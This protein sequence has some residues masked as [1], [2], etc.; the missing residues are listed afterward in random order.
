[1]ADGL[2][3]YNH[4]RE[5]GPLTPCIICKRARDKFGLAEEMARKIEQLP[6]STIAIQFMARVDVVVSPQSL[7]MLNQLAT[8]GIYGTTASAVAS[9]FVDQALQQYAERPTFRAALGINEK[10]AKR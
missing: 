3:T 6:D 2:P 1:M 10:K 5:D 9:R 4:S 7:D 8:M